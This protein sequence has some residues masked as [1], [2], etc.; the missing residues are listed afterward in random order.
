[1]LR[2]W[3]EWWPD[4]P[5]RATVRA[6]RSRATGKPGPPAEGSAGTGRGRPA[7]AADP[8]RH[9]G[10][11]PA[12]IQEASGR[13]PDAAPSPAARPRPAARQESA[14]PGRP[15]TD[16]GTAAA[17]QPRPRPPPGPAPATRPGPAPKAAQQPPAQPA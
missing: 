1:M 14:A 15:Q 4:G 12:H 9:A 16:Q 7:A 13:T 5:A 17:A 11:Q 8:A 6:G 2:G 10:N 3:Q